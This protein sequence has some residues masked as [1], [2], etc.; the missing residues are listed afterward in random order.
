MNDPVRK[1]QQT[2]IMRHDQHG[3]SPFPGDL[4]KQLHDRLAIGAIKRGGG[5]VGKDDGRVSDDGARDRHP[6][7]FA[8]AEFARIRL[9]LVGQADFCQ[10]LA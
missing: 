8:A 2:R 9:C 4:G 5:L 7:L 6:L 1:W 3:V 10:C